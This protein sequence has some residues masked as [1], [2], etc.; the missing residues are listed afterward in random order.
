MST[1]FIC[2]RV[3]FSNVRWGRVWAEIGIKN[4]TN[5]LFFFF[6]PCLSCLFLSLSQSSSS[7]FL[8]SSYIPSFHSFQLYSTLYDMWRS[9]GIWTRTATWHF[10]PLSLSLFSFFPHLLHQISFFHCNCHVWLRP[11]IV[12]EELI[13]N[14]LEGRWGGLFLEFSG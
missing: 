5:A 10:P 6:S 9:A 4:C 1:R 12:K 3:V 8:V 11:K 2:G 14:R 7:S 13:I